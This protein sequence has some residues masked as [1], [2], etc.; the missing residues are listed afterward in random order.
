MLTQQQKDDRR[1]YIG[2]SD[3]A[4]I[5]GVS[6]YKTIYQL[7]LEKTGRVVEQDISHKNYIKFGNYFEKGIA[8]WFC[9]ETKKQVKPN[10]SQNFIIHP[11]IPYLAGNIDFFIGDENSI[12]ECKTALNTNEWGDEQN[13]IPMHYLCQVAH[14]CMIGNFDKAYI[15]VVFAA[16]R[17]LKYYTYN[18]L[19]ELEVK[20]LDKIQHFWLNNVLEDIA[21]EPTNVDDLMLMYKESNNKP[22]VATDPIEVIIGALKMINKD[23]K[24]KEERKEELK[25]EICLYMKDH[26]TLLDI[27][28][29]SLATWKFT[30]P[31]KRF[32]TK[33]L[34]QENKN[35]YDKYVTECDP[36]RR[37]LIK[38]EK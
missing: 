20:L 32:D 29:K 8:H 33:K 27:N 18:R 6:P 15:A 30:R 23:I 2:G 10:Y 28:G 9:D 4:A 12:L 16:K 35:I 21:P 31:I 19:P 1:N 38:D 13:I 7:W 14:Y 37:F 3:V 34:E 24:A 22:I 36:Q 26:D 11:T 25:N 17:E 5:C